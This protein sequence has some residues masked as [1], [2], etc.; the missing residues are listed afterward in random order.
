MANDKVPENPSDVL[1]TD[2]GPEFIAPDNADYL[3]SFDEPAGGEALVPGR[4]P[5]ASPA[6]DGAKD[7][8]AVK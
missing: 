2:D 7:T 6:I 8:D 1:K 5:S 3:S 4:A